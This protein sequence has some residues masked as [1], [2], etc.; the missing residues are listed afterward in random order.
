ME[1]VVWPGLPNKDTKAVIIKMKAYLSENNRNLT[2][3][4]FIF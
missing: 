4:Y 1:L 3:Q 2:A